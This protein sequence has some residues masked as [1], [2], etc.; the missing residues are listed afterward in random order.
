VSRLFKSKFRVALAAALV[1]LA[2]LA[3]WAF[4]LEPA[5]TVVRRVSLS[6]PAWHAEHGGLKVALLTDLHVGAPHMS[7]G[8]LRNVVGRV[9]EEAPD[10]VIITGDF[11][12]GG[13]PDEGGERGGVAGGTFVEP[14]PLAEE[15]KHLR[16]PL[17]VY[18][19]L[20]NHDW[21]FDGERVAAA[22]AG[23]GLV[24]LEDRAVRIQHGGAALWLA[25]ISD[26][27]T[28][29]ADV[30]AALASIDDE[31]PVLALTHNPD[32]FPR[33]PDRV[34]LTLAGHTHGG[35]IDV[36]WLGPPVVPSKYGQRYAAG[37]VVEDGRHLFVGTG[38]GT[39]I[40]PIRVRVAPRIDVLIVRAR[41]VER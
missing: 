18:A 15:L 38:V 34:A 39:S 23:A 35:Q 8:R 30:D 20:G 12:I 16:A 14:E 7:L 40:L 13:P 24:V 17:G 3:A 1:V 5:S 4:W 32:V 22:L 41:G 11:V 37:H 31:A 10:L 6:V 19:V 2:C 29:A 28:R 21:W 27:C 9:N 33:V 26:V 36:P 25:G